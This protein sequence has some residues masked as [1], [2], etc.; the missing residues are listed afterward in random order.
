MERKKWSWCIGKDIVVIFFGEGVMQSVDMFLLRMDD[1]KASGDGPCVS[2]CLL[3][4]LFDTLT[5]GWFVLIDPVLKV[6]IGEIW[7]N[8]V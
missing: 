2:N 5:N 6:D 1:G 4:S 8:V 3:M 7:K